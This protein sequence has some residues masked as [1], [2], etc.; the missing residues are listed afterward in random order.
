MAPKV[1]GK[2]GKNAAASSAQAS[3]G[4]KTAKKK[5]WSKGKVSKLSYNLDIAFRDHTTQR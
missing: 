3:K 1:Q 5:K 2:A 4:G